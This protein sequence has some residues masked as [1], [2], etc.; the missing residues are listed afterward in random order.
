MLPRIKCLLVDDLRENLLALSALLQ[1]EDVE[2]LT[3]QSGPEALELLL[4]HDFALALLDVQMPEMDGFE[5][6][7]LMRGSERTRHVPII[8]VTAGAREQQRVFKGY[9]SGAVDFIYKPIEPHILKNKADVF[10]EL[11]RQRQQLAQELKERTETL[12][13]NEL[14]SALLAHDLRSPLSA[15]LASAEL[16]RRRSQDQHAQDAAV[17]ISVSGKHMGRLIEDMLDLARARL[18]GG[19]VIKREPADLKTL[20]ERVVREHQAAASGRIIHTEC[21]G[22]CA[23]EWDAERIAQ[24]ASNLIGNALKHGDPGGPVEVRLDGRNAFEVSLTVSNIG[25]IQPE[26]VKHLFDPFR[27]GQRPA[28]RSEGLGLGL[29]IVYQIVKAHAGSVEVLTGRDNWTT[30]RVVV[31]RGAGRRRA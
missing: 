16:L 26:L 29:Y 6:A 7:E 10:F 4:V 21:A 17:R 22:D 5:L 3:A 20:V 28:G 11:Y 12:R 2:P 25:S 31:P 24:V 8:F 23:G 19:I 14:F 18:A 13:L 9:E 27:G 30:F 1:S 15:I